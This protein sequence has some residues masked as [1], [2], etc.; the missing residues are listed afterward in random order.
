MAFLSDNE[1]Y[2]LIAF[3]VAVG[4]LIRQGWGQVARALDAR[5]QSIRHQLDEAKRLRAEAEA[6]LAQ[7]QRKQR[8]AIAEAQE[9]IT[10]AQAEAERVAK[11]G[12]AD[13]EAAIKRREE[14]ARDK[15]AQAEIKALAEIRTAAVD[16]AMAAIRVLLAQALDPARGSRLIDQAIEDLPQRLH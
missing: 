9:I 15:I 1:F 8:D 7:F 13:L 11:Q 6:L 4:I 2:I 5:A 10:R 3:L 14:Q 12:E 16:V